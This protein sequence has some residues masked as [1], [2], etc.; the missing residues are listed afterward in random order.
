MPFQ[1]SDSFLLQKGTYK[2]INVQMKRK[3]MFGDG[4]ENH[5]LTVKILL[6]LLYNQKKSVNNNQCL[7]I[8]CFQK[9]YI[10]STDLPICANL[11]QSVKIARFLNYQSL[12]IFTNC[13]IKFKKYQSLPMAVGNLTGLGMIGND[14]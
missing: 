1:F 8:Y 10:C 4:S 6:K 5:R 12:P 9:S 3:L 2:L 13:Q 14:W 11:Y 7:P